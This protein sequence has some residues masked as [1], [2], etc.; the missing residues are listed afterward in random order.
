[1]RAAHYIAR[2]IRIDIT[3]EAFDAI[4]AT[5]PFGSVGYEAQTQ[6]EG[7]TAGLDRGRPS[8]IA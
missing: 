3:P 2:M 4:A 6:R 1:M 7:R 5:L 8:S